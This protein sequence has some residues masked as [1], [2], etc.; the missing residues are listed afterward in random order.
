MQKRCLPLSKTARQA[1][2][3]GVVLTVFTQ[4]QADDYI[5]VIHQVLTQLDVLR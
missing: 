1:P 4:E 3:L 2:A 5:G